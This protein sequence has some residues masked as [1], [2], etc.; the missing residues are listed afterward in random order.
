[1]FQDWAAKR[2]CKF[3]LKRLL[4]KFIQG[5]LDLDGLEVQ[6][7][8]G[9]VQLNGLAL[10][11]DYLNEQLGV[12]PVIIKEGFIGSISIKIPWK[13][14]AAEK[15]EINVEELELVLVPRTEAKTSSNSEECSTSEV[16]S[17]T[18]SSR[19]NS[20]QVEGCGVPANG[21]Y[22][23]LGV[24][25]G[26]K[27]IAKMVERL[28]LGLHIKIRSVIIVFEQATDTC[29][30]NLGVESSC[31]SQSILALRVLQT[32]YGTDVSG[33]A[34][35]SAGLHPDNATGHVMLTKI[36]N[37]HGVTVDLYDVVEKDTKPASLRPIASLLSGRSA[38]S[39]PGQCPVPIIDG[40]GSGFSGSVQLSIPW[41]SGSMDIPKVNAEIHFVP[42]KLQL[43]PCTIQRLISLLQSIGE[44]RDKA[45]EPSLRSS[46]RQSFR[47]STGFEN[48][49]HRSCL[50]LEESVTSTTDVMF[51]SLAESFSDLPSPIR[52]ETA[53]STLIPDSM[54]ISNWVQN[55][56]LGESVDEFFECMD[57][58][59]G[60]HVGPANSGL[61]SLTYSVFGAI[62]AAST[63]A[64]GSV[65]IPSRQQRVECNLNV[66]F[67][68]VS[69][70]LAFEDH[71]HSLKS[72]WHG[73][74][75]GGEGSLTR[76]SD[77]LMG[78]SVSKLVSPM[79]SSRVEC[80]QQET[81]CV[82]A[83]ENY[84]EANIED[85]SFSVQISAQEVKFNTMVKQFEI[86][87]YLLDKSGKGMEFSLSNCAECSENSMFSI[88]NLQR[89]VEDALPQFPV[90][91][92][93]PEVVDKI[94]NMRNK[95]EVLPHEAMANKRCKEKGS[96][97]GTF[98]KFVKIKLLVSECDSAHHFSLNCHFGN[99][100]CNDSVTSCTKFEAQLQ[101]FVLWL[102]FYVANKLCQ[103]IEGFGNPCKK[104]SK[105]SDESRDVC[106]SSSKNDAPQGNVQGN[107]SISWGRVILCFPV[108]I[109]K[110]MSPYFLR[111][112]FICI[113]L[114]ESA[115][116]QKYQ[117]EELL[118]EDKI[119]KDCRFSSSSIVNL[120]MGEGALFL[121]FPS[122]TTNARRIRGDLDELHFSARKV[123]TI[124]KEKEKDYSVLGIQWLDN[125]GIGPRNAERAWGEAN[126]HW[127]RGTGSKRMSENNSEFLGANTAGASEFTD[128][129]D[130]K[131]MIQSSA[132]L[133]HFSLPH[134]Q[135]N[136]YG[137]DHI[138]VANLLSLLTDCIFFEGDKETCLN[139]E[140][141]PVKKNLSFAS[142]GS[143][144]HSKVSQSSFLFE[145]KAVEIA[146]HLTESVNIRASMEKELPGSWAS[147]RLTVRNFEVLSVSNLGGVSGASYLWLNHDEGLL[148]GSLSDKMEQPQSAGKVR[149]L[150]L[151][152]CK[153][154]VLGRGDGGGRNAL[155][156]GNAGTTIIH[157]DNPQHLQSLTS[158]T[159]RCGT[160][161]APGGRLD[162]LASI[163][164]FFGQSDDDEQQ[165]ANTGPQEELSKDG[166]SYTTSFLLELLDIA[167]SYEPFLEAS[168]INSLS[169]DSHVEEECAPV[170]CI[171]AA[172]ALR[173]SIKAKPNIDN[174]KYVILLE[175]VG[176]LLLD[177]SEG[178]N[179]KQAYDAESLH[180]KGYVKIAGEAIMNLE[181]EM[182]CQDN[183]LWKV[184]CTE[185]NI[186]LDTCHD[187]TAALIRLVVQLQQLFAPD[188]E[189]S[190]V[191]LQTRQDTGKQVS[192]FEVNDE[193]FDE[194]SQIHG[195]SVVFPAN[196]EHSD[197]CHTSEAT[198]VGLMDVIV[199][200]AFSS[201]DLAR[202][203]NENVPDS[204]VNGLLTQ[205]CFLL[206]ELTLDEG[207][208]FEGSVSASIFDVDPSVKE[209]ACCELTSS[210][211]PEDMHAPSQRET[212]FS[213]I[214]DYYIPESFPRSPR[215][216]NKQFKVGESGKTS[217]TTVDGKGGWYE[218]S[219]LRIL[220]NHISNTD[221]MQDKVDSSNSSFGTSNLAGKNIEP[222]GRISLK[223]LRVTWRMCAG[224][225]WPA[226]KKCD[227]FPMLAD[228]ARNSSSV[229]EVQLHGMNFQYDTFPE[230]GL[231][232]SKLAVS[233]QDL[234]ILDRSEHAPWKMVLLDYHTRMHPR[235]SSAKAL[236][237]EL[238]AVKPDP[239]T[240]LEE[241]RLL[242]KLLPLRL[243][244]DQSQ[245]DFLIKFF[246]QKASSVAE[247]GDVSGDRQ[248]SSSVSAHATYS[249]ELSAT[250]EGLLP[251]FQKCEI[252]PLTI[253][254]D[255]VPRRVDLVALRGGNYAELLNLVS[256]KGIDLNLKGVE[257]GGISGWSSVSE[258]VVGKWLEDISQN[259]V[260]K[261][262]KGV[263][264][265]RS[266]FA[267]GCGAAK[268]FSLPAEHYRK[269]R[270]LLKGLQKGVI[271]FLR[272]I[273]LEAVGCGVHLAA[274]A[275]GILI[276]TE[277]ALSSIPPSFSLASR[278]NL[279]MA[280]KINQ[281][282]DAS[283]GLRQAYESLTRG[284]ER[285]AA[286]LIGN[287]IKSYTRGEGAG[288]ALLSAVQAA[289]AAAL[290]PASAAAGAVH[291]ALLGVRNSL[292][293]D[294]KKE[295]EEKH[296]GTVPVL[297]FD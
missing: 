140:G 294:H 241:Y 166:N 64:S 78:N 92:C 204:A 132:I 286:S 297:I 121:V 272:S 195:S 271:A 77:V 209:R 183:L 9:T 277:S 196:K 165:I 258:I 74:C 181:V 240:P 291:C 231:Y 73:D 22:T 139:S 135:L 27:M 87:E 72:D 157:L 287:P 57:G 243:H 95:D 270:R 28:L 136:L 283:Q 179:S 226:W 290:A 32:E 134:A 25:D 46:N 60:L 233:I 20:E 88:G 264:P 67:D 106:S 267:L 31:Q 133:I 150:C 33:D 97:S 245:L 44:C 162:W 151:L 11:T 41:K 61:W 10:N 147:F 225:D 1:M 62:T 85:L 198:T 102:D 153:T 110:D 191:H 96:T 42:V 232:S 105:I 130:R 269:D 50:H 99:M 91:L 80:L 51:N 81:G 237:F 47:Q 89:T 171:L 266:L 63:L 170:S 45:S 52:E 288:H 68:G 250:E 84:L 282:G 36:I 69:V 259:Q 199:E 178:R 188:Y 124:L 8:A 111:D 152:C 7:G 119:L 167:V 108:E 148:Y 145:C 127:T 189:E 207:C 65:L 228:S 184:T 83:E 104:F 212:C 29:S 239:S 94:T 248:S 253:H 53:N 117:Q 295:S 260:H 256:W 251:F 173:L 126:E 190:A 276:H 255:Y 14:L 211:R 252:H 120:K 34:C 113:D 16:Y 125:S 66:R 208:A 229:L 176:L 263:A 6:L 70:I 201:G 280:G 112:N 71:I 123:F 219:T 138:L 193:N 23:Y 268:L 30:T 235:E 168:R 169:T 17:S 155:A 43:Q 4:G 37:F 100:K 278:E 79:E 103:L 216:E 118:K 218:D 49:L 164:S 158:V 59:R 200:N 244:L 215:F 75:M 289:P 38:G 284:F 141:K 76:E 281:P 186:C 273:S 137:P 26:V 236:K 35:E 275:H 296:S 58:T 254:V 122:K 54:I 163:I 2:V 217:N 131:E 55:V 143:T 203:K 128:A 262:L 56:D 177:L 109:N 220:E 48:D 82:D 174:K 194:T 182:N 12:T 5:E 180:S 159:I 224:S 292:D 161:V 142:N 15:C 223:N 21:G 101:P 214:E 3:F 146:I 39:Q 246:S 185:G 285:T 222:V 213:F 234:Q 13:A 230:G 274:G 265:I 206:S 160:L 247:Q 221:R 156:S 154:N 172:A 40:N 86:F 249:K 187:T 227:S 279:E 107:V 149:E 210:I 261:L 18:T 293:L 129:Y 238:E 192:C 90:S 115:S 197:I 175:D 116:A 202:L 19:L 257:T 114:S 93:S 242:V 98:K 144:S 205:S 24:Q